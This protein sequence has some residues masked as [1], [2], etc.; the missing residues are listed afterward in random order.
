VVKVAHI[1]ISH[2]SSDD[3]FVK[4]LRLALEAHQLPVWVDSRALVGGNELAPEIDTAIEQARQV[5]V[6]LSPNT[7][8]SPW[9]RKE[10]GKALAVK[11]EKQDPSYRVIPLL[12]P[13]IEPAALPLWFNEE[14]VG[15]RVELKTGAISEALPQI[16]AA[17]GEQLPDDRQRVTEQPTRPAAELKLELKHGRIEEIGQGKW[18][19]LATAQLIYDP[20]DPARPAAESSEFRFT[21]PLGPIEA[22]ELR[23][24]LEEYY[25]W[26]TTF[27]TERAK[28]IEEQLPQ[29]GRQ[30]YEAATAAQSARDLMSDWQQSANGIERRFS[31]FVDSRVIEGSSEDEQAAA[32]EAASALLALPWELMHDGRSFL[33]QGNHAVRVRRCLPKQRAEKAVA[34]SLPIRILLVSPRPEDDRAPYI[35][36][37]ISARPLVSAIESLGELAELTVLDPPTLPALRQ[38][39]R[40]AS[41]NNRPFDV[42]HFDGHG[43]YDR[44]RSLGALCFE[45]PKDSDKL[46]RRAS[47]LINAEEL[48][49]LVKEHRIPLV[50][51]EACQS[52]AEE[53]PSASVAAKLLDEGVTSVV[54]M[55][56]SVLVETARRF[57]TAFY[58]E[59]AEGKRIGTA[60]LAGQQALY[61]DDF[62]FHVMGAGEL[63]LKDWFVPVLYQEENDPRLIT[64][65]LPEDVRRL[66]QQRRRLSLG[67]LPEPPAHSFIGRSR[68]LLKLE[69]MLA[70]NEQRYVMVRGRGGEGKTT[71]AVELARWL[72]ETRRFERAAFVSLEE[73]TDARGVL[74]KLG[75]QL[76]P[77]GENWHVAD[78]AEDFEQGRQQVERALRDHRTVIVLD[79][80]ESILASAKPLEEGRKETEVVSDPPRD[81]VKEIFS[82]CKALLDAGPATRMIFTSR[83]PLPEPFAHRHRTA[84]LRELE[85][86]D[87]IELVSQVMKREGIEPKHDDA[88]NTPR[89]VAELVEAVGCHARALTLLAREI[90]IQ[91]VSATT[92][93][94]QRLMEELERKHPGERENSLYASVELSLRRLPPEMRQ[95]IKPLGV[96]YGGANLAMLYY[97]LDVDEQT[98]LNIGQALITAGLAEA[99]AYRHLQLDPALAPYLLR[100][101]S[102]AEQEAARLRWAEAMKGL[103][104]FLYQQHF[105]DAE[106]SAQLTLLEVPNLMALLD[107]IEECDTPKE[108]VEV[109]QSLETLLA[110]LGRSQTLARATR[111]REGA[112]LRL[113]QADAWSH[114]RYL[115]ESAKINRL[116]E[117]GQLPAAYQAAQQLLTSSLMGG[118]AAY[119]E[120]GYDTAM[121][122]WQL[123]SVLQMAGAA[124]AALA[125]LSEAKRRF[126]TLADARDTTAA[127]MDSSTIIMIAICLTNLGRLDEAAMAYQEAIRLKEEQGDQ[128]G[129]AVSKANFGTIRLHQ[130]RHEEAL[131]AYIEAR[132]RFESLGEP[133]SVAGAWYQIGMVH[134]QTGQFE[135][136]ESA[137]RRALAIRVREKL[138]SDEASSLGELGNLYATMGQLEESV[139][140]YQQSADICRRLQNDNDEGLIRHNLANA[141]IKLEQYGEARR[142]LLRAIECKQAY[143]H[144]AGPWKTWDL[145]HDLE[146][147]TGKRAAAAEARQRAIG[148]YLAYRCDGGQSYG[149]GAQACAAVS[150]AIGQGATTALAQR[151]AVVLA[152]TVDPRPHALVSKLQAI[153]AGSRDLALADDPELFYQDAVELRLLLESLGAS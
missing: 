52:A 82:L 134:L 9:V 91:G 153:L 24:Y 49:A 106:L 131:A 150:E 143:G 46:E 3:A 121:I 85:P 15:V 79:N 136:A 74:M 35:D 18:R 97:V 19:A 33:F 21:A 81:F 42:I 100:D 39:L 32:N 125:S 90:A 141:L 116:V 2:A 149:W 129:I 104:G 73:Y 31:I 36:H 138:V 147:A 105:Q 124:E 89:E 38:A 17:L 107:W 16:L 137:H 4:E 50:F 55:T 22:D 135:Q 45:D 65:L 40:Q 64:H 127:R 62:R 111:V 145:L 148:A 26:P 37:R 80:V 61:D 99:M 10:I 34:S 151:L 117:G 25:R 11:R 44:Q 83:E 56:H 112:A 6:V 152:Q 78:N 23:W 75:Q 8:N 77:E 5:I 146:Q 114:T 113:D 59:L 58:G 115:A 140:C 76:L 96:F 12:L 54:A 14:P 13:G 94:V 87:A 132:T 101:L 139:K 126:Q 41:E 29:W 1:F 28:R 53:K 144:A 30:L 70:N 71:L 88:G 68:D 122:Y 95:Q 27:F 98:A 120:A 130:G 72:V 47:Q 119:P 108:V 43:V 142:E 7:I 118:E 133:A 102:E 128:R 110:P 48:A 109:A 67:A 69:R 123:G 84:E 86:N 66:H 57:V 51:L 103:T 63:R 60:M 20:A 93:N 92:G